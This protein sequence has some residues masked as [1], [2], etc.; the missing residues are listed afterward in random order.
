MSQIGKLLLDEGIARQQPHCQ[1]K[2][3]DLQVGR[4]NA[5]TLRSGSGGL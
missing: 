5:G 1:G 2:F 3:V 4:V